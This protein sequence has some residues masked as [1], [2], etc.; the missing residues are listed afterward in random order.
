MDDGRD[1]NSYTV[2]HPVSQSIVRP[3]TLAVVIESSST[4]VI[5]GVADVLRLP[6]DGRRRCRAIKSRKREREKENNLFS[7][8]FDPI[9]RVLLH[10]FLAT[11]IIIIIV[12][13][14][15]CIV[16]ALHWPPPPPLLLLHRISLL[17]NRIV[18]FDCLRI[19]HLSPTAYSATGRNE[20]PLIEGKVQFIL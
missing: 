18:Y 5:L 10:I 19:R 12:T 15:L 7:R 1:G 6:G 9:F 8:E 4:H 20:N 2:I 11:V 16:F 14:G 13:V 3:S 17:L